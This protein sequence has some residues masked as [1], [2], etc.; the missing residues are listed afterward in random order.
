MVGP[1][2]QIQ[3]DERI[4]SALEE[5]TGFEVIRIM[6]GADQTGK[7]IYQDGYQF[8]GGEYSFENHLQQR[9]VVSQSRVDELVKP[10]KPAPVA[11]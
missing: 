10:A 6:V 8:S 2:S 3:N 9:C 5:I 7:A 11:K 4:L 1:M